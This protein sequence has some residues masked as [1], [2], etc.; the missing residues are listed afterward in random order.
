MERL[1]DKSPIALVLGMT[2]GVSSSLT[3][4]LRRPPCRFV[5]L[6]SVSQPYA[7]Y[8]GSAGL[9]FSG[10]PPVLTVNFRRHFS[11]TR[12]QTFDIRPNFVVRDTVL[13]E[14]RLGVRN[15]LLL[16]QDINLDTHEEL[17]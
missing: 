13:V 14:H 16:W 12:A 5:A 9:N 15:G 2:P 6:T 11:Q 4:H 7:F 1:W 8:I 3:R 17:L 10:L